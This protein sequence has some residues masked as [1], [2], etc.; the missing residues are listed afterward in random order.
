MRQHRFSEV[1]FDT[2]QMIDFI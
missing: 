2:Q 1:N